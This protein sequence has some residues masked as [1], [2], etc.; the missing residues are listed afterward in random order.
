MR[1]KWYNYL[2]QPIAYLHL[3]WIQREYKRLSLKSARNQTNMVLAR[4]ILLQA[5]E[6]Y[7]RS[8]FDCW[9]IFHPSCV[10]TPRH[11]RIMSSMFPTK[12]YAELCGVKW[13]S[14][15]ALIYYRNLLYNNNVKTASWN[16]SICG[17]GTFNFSKFPFYKKESFTF[18]K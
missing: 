1:K 2:Y 7:Y 12:D 3:K 4:L 10:S 13:R 11:Q 15:D 18:K 16:N 8:C 17:P 14:E 9:G 6:E 5:K